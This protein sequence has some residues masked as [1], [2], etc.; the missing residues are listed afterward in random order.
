[1]SG[2]DLVTIGRERYRVGTWRGDPGRGYVAPLTPP[3][4]SSPAA[5]RRLVERLA[6]Q[7]Y[8][9]ILT[10]ALAET[11]QPSF[12][13]A[14]FEVHE[15]LHLLQHDLAVLPSRT[16]TVRIRR[17]RPWERA[18]VLS[19]DGKAFDSFW[20]LDAASL[21][22]AVAATPASR[23]VVATIDRQIVGYAVSG[24]A[25]AHGYLQRLAVDPDRQGHGIGRELVADALRWMAPRASAA[26]VNTQ[27][28]NTRA[29]M[30]YERTGFR[31]IMPGLAVLRFRCSVQ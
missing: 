31:R 7:G 14:G 12:L 4:F 5:I 26:S 29:L 10:A 20:R 6:P 13:Q 21:D 1:M 9:E 24:A 25:T 30:L 16:G 17:A 28:H 23:F 3:Q 2:L 11:E 15:R 19:I 27:E 22:E 18:R 8:D